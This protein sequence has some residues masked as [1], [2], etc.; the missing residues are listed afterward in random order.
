[1]IRFLEHQQIDKKKWDAALERSSHPLPYAYSWYLDAIAPG[2]Q[3]LVEDDYAAIMPLTHKTKYKI[4]YLYPPYFA[5]QLGVFSKNAPDKKKVQEF[6]DLLPQRFK[7][8]EILMNTGN[9]F[10]LDNFQ[11]KKN[12]NIEL[13]LNRTYE[14]LWKDYSEDIRRNIKKS[15][16]YTFDLKKNIDQEDIIRLFRKNTGRKITNLQNENYRT[17]NTLIGI[18]R[19]KGMAET[20]G[21]YLENKLCAGIVWLHTS[22][23]SIFLFS[24]TNEM[25]RKTG[26]MH[27]LIDRF[28][29]E[30]AGQDRILD[31]EGSNLPGL[32]RFYKGFGSEETVYLQVRKNN[33]PR[34]LRWLKK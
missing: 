27:A 18:C 12:T 32:A 14:Q 25:A 8:I 9:T 28:I 11:T 24:A 5:Q 29:K 22:D 30:H 20:W 33:L 26:A 4:S 17:L 34:L 6:L 15:L 21:L 1:M 10:A 19:Q 16:R 2:W 13:S 31:F 7:F 3:A 23:R